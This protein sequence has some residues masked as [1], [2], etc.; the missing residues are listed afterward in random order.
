MLSRTPLRILPNVTSRAVG[1]R[2]TSTSSNDATNRSSPVLRGAYHL[3]KRRPLCRIVL[4]RRR[5]EIARIIHQHIEALPGRRSAAI[6]PR[7]GH[8]SPM[9]TL[10]PEQ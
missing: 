10:G 7:N 6:S 1:G 8:S 2:L 4:R 5:D 3:R 9:P